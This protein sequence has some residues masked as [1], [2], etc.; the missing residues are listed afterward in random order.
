MLG[1]CGALR[2]NV[3]VTRG[4]GQWETKLA[5]I[6][7]APETALP[8][9][10]PPAASPWSLNLLRPLDLRSRKSM[11][12]QH[13]CPTCLLLT[14]MLATCG[15][16]TRARGVQTTG[17]R[18][19]ALP[20]PSPVLRA[21]APPHD[22]LP[23]KADS[24]LVSRPAVK[25]KKQPTLRGRF[26]KTSRE[27]PLPSVAAVEIDAPGC[28]YNPDYEQHQACPPRPSHS[29]RGLPLI[30]R[31]LPL[32]GLS[33]PPLQVTH[34]QPRPLPSP[35]PQLLLLLY[36]TRSPRSLQDLPL[37]LPSPLLCRMQSRRPSQP[38]STRK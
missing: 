34:A 29:S 4:C 16:R 28:S 9:L 14:E 23:Q 38:R 18:C 2:Y 33:A 10:V 35:T 15:R 37:P 27:M 17:G 32:V 7:M 6:C 21:L 30:P 5:W 11:P 19:A 31:S 24:S 12:R 20:S 25:G 13:P 36:P 22:P 26:S 1:L 8:S 3:R